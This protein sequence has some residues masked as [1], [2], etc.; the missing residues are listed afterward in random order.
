MKYRSRFLKSAQKDLHDVV[1]YISQHSFEAAQGFL[2]ELD[3]R[4]LQICDF[5][6]SC[7][8]CRTAPVLRRMV[9]GH[10]LVFYEEDEKNDVINIY[11]ILHSSRNIEK[12][13][14]TGEK[15]EE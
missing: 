2:D 1:D 11:R 14:L 9:V 8:A 7:E 5:P 4:I 3:K 12:N 13:N 15:T 6:K 10:Y